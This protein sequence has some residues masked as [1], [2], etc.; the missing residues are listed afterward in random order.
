[1]SLSLASSISRLRCCTL[2]IVAIVGLSTAD[3]Q[4]KANRF[5]KGFAE[6]THRV[7]I[8]GRATDAAEE[9][10]GGAKV[11]VYSQ[12]RRYSPT[13]I[14]ATTTT[15]AN[16]RYSFKDIN[17]PVFE[18]PPEAVPKPIEG[19]FQVFATSNAHGFLWRKPYTYRP[20]ARPADE[21]SKEIFYRDEP[22]Q[23]D[24]QF[25]EPAR[26]RGTITN[27]LGEPVEGA[28][29]QVGLINRVEDQE[30]KRP[31]M[32]TCAYREGSDRERDGSFDGLQFLPEA[33]R[34]ARTDA[35]GRYELRHL[36]GDAKMLYF[37]DYQREYRPVTG[38]IST[39]TSKGADNRVVAFDGELNHI[40]DVP[41]ALEVKVTYG[42]GRLPVTG[43]TVRATTNTIMRAGHIGHTNDEGIAILRLPPGE[44]KI[45]ADPPLAEPIASVQ[46]AVEITAQSTI[47]TIELFADSRVKVAFEAVSAPE[48][49][50]S[51]VAGVRVLMQ[52]GEDGD[53]KEVQ[54]RQELLDHPRTA[55]DGRFDAIVEPGR[56]RFV[57]ARAPLG[58]E[59]SS[60]TS[61]WHDLKVGESPCIRLQIVPTTK[62]DALFA[63]I[64]PKTDDEKLMR[65]LADKMQK[66][67]RP[68][69]GR[70]HLRYR[71]H[72]T[73]PPHN[74]LV[75]LVQ[76]L[77]RQSLDD[78][79]TLLQ[80]RLPELQR[81]AQIEYIF[82]DQRYRSIS[83]YPSLKGEEDSVSDTSFN[84]EEEVHWRSGSNQVDLFDHA[85][86]NRHMLHLEEIWMRPNFPFMIG[87]IRAGAAPAEID[88]RRNGTAVEIAVKSNMNSEI[89]LDASTGFLRQHSLRMSDRDEYLRDRWQLFP[90][91]TPDDIVYPQLTLMVSNG[92]LN[93]CIIDRVELVDR[94][95][96][97]AFTVALPAGTTVVSYQGISRQDQQSTQPR[98]SRLPHDVLDIAAHVAQW[99]APRT[100][101]LQIG[102]T[103]PPMKPVAWVNQQGQV[104]AP[105][106][107]GKILLIDFWGI[108]C[109]PCVAELPEVQEAAKHFTDSDLTIIGWHD[110]SGTVESL[111]EF[112][113]K[114]GL[115]Y[116]LAIDA[117][118]P[119]FG[120]AFAAYDVNGIPTA[121]V[122]DRKGLVAFRGR[123]KEAL[124]V[125]NRLLQQTP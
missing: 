94:L 53:W 69:Q 55:P 45:A 34:I 88:V 57:A 9:P 81:L 44:Y 96:I 17:L 39:S 56:Y 99:P 103:A 87:Q 27:D 121:I 1:M 124:E 28:V 19:A 32:W 7:T 18:Y 74:E 51:P 106:L 117:R 122:V 60:N 33:F 76:S 54:S 110:S 50:Q 65:E 58:Y 68:I 4:D 15:N 52:K 48:H 92:Y 13:A 116:P 91:A 125:A 38:T 109:G 40:F 8:S 112:A 30:G 82:D 21:E 77:E 111:K 113:T 2:V 24:V 123:F 73:S 95:P 16:G 98:V 63:P 20:A 79:V 59:L 70:I 97:D 43:A 62:H 104:D 22:L 66:L 93:V 29:V 31:H 107:E 119:G 120:A 25:G 67:R 102:Q 37:I 11:Y 86:S 72:V 118:G 108:S 23:V 89:V 80:E 85:S 64:E 78:A 6:E 3:A 47:Q 5:S 41:R 36:P 46:Q 12:N 114:K 61:E 84:G 10:V 83:R 75:Q 35:S 49:L 115:T 105:K 101:K 71:N 42:E 26:L 100:P 14:L 90:S